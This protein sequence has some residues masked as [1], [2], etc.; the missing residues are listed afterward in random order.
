[1]TTPQPITIGIDFGT[2]NSVVA[3]ADPATGAELVRFTVDGA[4]GV[5]TF[6]SALSFQFHP[7]EDGG[8]AVQRQVDRVDALQLVARFFVMPAHREA[9]TDHESGDQNR[10]PAA[11]TEFFPALE[12]ACEAAQPRSLGLRQTI[13]SKLC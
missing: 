11:G 7:A 8:R 3:L 9:D 12:A 4:G 13:S 5:S 10:D 2:T 6:R 1:M